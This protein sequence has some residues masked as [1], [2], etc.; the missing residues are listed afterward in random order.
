MNSD[1]VLWYVGQH[2][3]QNVTPTQAYR[4]QQSISEASAEGARLTVGVW[5]SSGATRL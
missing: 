2:K 3:T 4:P 5:A 1:D